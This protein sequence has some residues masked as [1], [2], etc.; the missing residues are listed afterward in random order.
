LLQLTALTLPLAINFNSAALD[1][2]LRRTL[3]QRPERC[4]LRRRSWR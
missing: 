4:T 3:R 2:L 1:A